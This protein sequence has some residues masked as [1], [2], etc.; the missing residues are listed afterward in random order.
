M[1]KK[2][3]KFNIKKV[4]EIYLQRLYKFKLSMREIFKIG[5]YPN[6]QKKYIYIGINQFK[7]DFLRGLV[8]EAPQLKEYLRVY[9][10]EEI[11][12]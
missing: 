11:V 9:N 12:G 1:K 2:I 10:D 8:K 5:I 7:N 3:E 6:I 4:N